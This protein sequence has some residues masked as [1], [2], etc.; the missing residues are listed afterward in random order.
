[1]R[2]MFNTYPWAFATPGGGEMQLRKYA[3]HLPDLA[4][5]VILHD[6]WN[7]AFDKVSLVHFFSCIGGSIPFCNYVKSRGLPLVITS[8]PASSRSRTKNL[9]QS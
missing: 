6:I 2:V 1:M 9:P 5:E 8:S 4:V 7:P 3:E